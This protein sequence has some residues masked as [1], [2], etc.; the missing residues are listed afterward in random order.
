MQ[1]AMVG[2]SGCLFTRCFFYLQDSMHQPTGLADQ[3]LGESCD[4]LG[5]DM[6]ALGHLQ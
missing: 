5:G 6:E 2:H 3:D 1:V 4:A